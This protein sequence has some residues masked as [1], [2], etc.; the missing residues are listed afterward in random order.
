MDGR[1]GY[2]E[3]ISFESTWFDAKFRCNNKDCKRILNHKTGLGQAAQVLVAAV[4]LKA[5]I[6]ILGIGDLEDFIDD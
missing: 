1:E 5:A 3:K 2:L 4:G 6:A